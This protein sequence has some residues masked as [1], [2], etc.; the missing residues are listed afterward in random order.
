[1][2]GD[3]TENLV[4][5]LLQVVEVLGPWVS[6]MAQVFGQRLQFFGNFLPCW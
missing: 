6:N 1:M 2:P 4:W 3:M 5:P